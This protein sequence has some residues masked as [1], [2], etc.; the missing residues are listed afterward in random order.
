MLL[1]PTTLLVYFSFIQ[2]GVI[3]LILGAITTP[4]P[5]IP[6]ATLVP[7]PSFASPHPS[8]LACESIRHCRTLW[9][10]VWSCFGT[11]FACVWIAVH[12]NIPG[13]KQT[14]IAVQLCWLMALILTLLIPEWILAWAIRQWIRVREIAKKLEE[15]RVAAQIGWETKYQASSV[16]TD[17]ND[18]ETNVAKHQVQTVGSDQLKG[19]RRLFSRH[20][21]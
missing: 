9:D 16:E 17:E 3:A 4:L 14:L 6:T 7:T 11:I 18:R 15:A 19:V 5:P 20:V 21:T 2:N 12:R 1:L 10:I 8:S 13:P